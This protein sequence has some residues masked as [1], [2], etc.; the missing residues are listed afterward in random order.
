M[1]LHVH[2]HDHNIPPAVPI[3]PVHT[4]PPILP[5]TAHLNSTL[6]C[7]P[8]SSQQPPYQNPVFS[9]RLPHASHISLSLILITLKKC[10]LQYKSCSYSI[11][12][13]LQSPVTAPSQA[14]K[15]SS[16]LC[17][18][19]PQINTIFW[20]RYLKETNHWDDL[21]TDG[22]TRVPTCP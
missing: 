2:Y 20:Y 5:F 1:T 13:L 4:H 18:Y 15:S 8:V 21:V 11:R 9:F 17:T 12:S 7:T 14:Q 3:H 19:I 16:A 22:R 10:C 6:P